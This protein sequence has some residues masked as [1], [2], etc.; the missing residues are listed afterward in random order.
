MVNCVTYHIC[1]CHRRSIL[2]IKYPQL[3]LTIMA[4]DDGSTQE[5][6]LPLPKFYFLVSWESLSEAVSF[7]E[8]S[9]L[10]TENQAIE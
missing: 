8:V 1:S 7:Q 10:D 4:A 2:N 6:N 5:N 9:G 3:N